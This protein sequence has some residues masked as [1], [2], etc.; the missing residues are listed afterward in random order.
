MYP[1]TDLPP[2]RITDQRVENIKLGVSEPFWEREVRYKKIGVPDDIIPELSVSK[3]AQL[4]SDVVSNGI[5]PVTAA[6]VLV[7]Y[8]KRLKKNGLDTGLLNEEIYRSLFQ[9]LREGRI[10]REAIYPILENYLTAGNFIFITPACPTCI[11]EEIEKS[12]TML[13]AIQFHD[14][15]NRKVLKMS[16]IMSALRG[17]VEGNKIASLIDLNGVKNGI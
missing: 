17:R 7:Q 13:S 12:E 11:T 4:F 10:L 3:Y 5:S 9:E 2:Q 14:E 6:V 16:I 8:P 1:D 15:K